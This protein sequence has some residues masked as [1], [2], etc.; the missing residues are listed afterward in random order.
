MAREWLRSGRYQWINLPACLTIRW[1][2]E[3]SC[4]RCRWERPMIRRLSIAAIVAGILSQIAGLAV[5][6][7]LHARDASL[8]E[9]EGVLS[10]GNPGH[11]LFA[12]GL[13]LAILGAGALLTS[14]LL[15]R[16]KPG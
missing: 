12:G 1:A 15:A 6:S 9:R 16:R 3:Q 5:D 7:I 11:L 13:A 8:S 14:P 2:R 10:L 4:A